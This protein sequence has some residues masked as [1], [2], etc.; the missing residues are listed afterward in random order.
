[1]SRILILGGA[2]AALLAPAAIAQASTGPVSDEPVI[3]KQS[4]VGLMARRGRGADDAPGDDRR[5]RGRGTD[6]GPNHT[7][8]DN[9]QFDQFA[10]RGRGADDAP[11]DD[12]RGRGRGTDDGPNHS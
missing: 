6:D 8:K 1:M 10:R 9:G 4:D 7:L 11:G 2:L 12:R 3:S 5:G